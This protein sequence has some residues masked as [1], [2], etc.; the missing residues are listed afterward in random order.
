[1]SP[2]APRKQRCFRGAKG[3][4]ETVISRTIL[5]QYPSDILHLLDY[6]LPVLQRSPM[7]IVLKEVHRQIMCA[8]DVHGQ[9]GDVK[10]VVVKCVLYREAVREISRWSAKR[11]TGYVKKCLRTLTR[12][13]DS[14]FW[15]PF[16][17]RGTTLSL[18]EV[19]LSATTC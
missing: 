16:R 12:V 15:H 2:F 19:R 5:T 13:P 1:M 11:H 3:D 6:D 17:M 14:R 7:K 4:K 10:D 18:P 9:H 8:S